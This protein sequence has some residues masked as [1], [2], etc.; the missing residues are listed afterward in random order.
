MVPCASIEMVLLLLTI[1]LGYLALSHKGRGR[2]KKQKTPS[3]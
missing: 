3:S 2:L 1:F